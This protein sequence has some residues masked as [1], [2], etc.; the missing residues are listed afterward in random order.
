MKFLSKLSLI[1]FISVSLSACQNTFLSNKQINQGF[2]TELV[3]GGDFLITTAQKITAPSK[4]YVFYI[5]GD[6]M[7]FIGKHR[8]SLNPTPRHQMVL[9]LTAIDQRPNVIY[10]SRPCQYTPMELNPKCSSEYWSTKRMSEETVDSIN[11]V[12]TKINN[13]QKFSLVGFSGGGGI[14]VLIAARNP[15]V[16]DVITIAGNIDHETFTDFHKVTPMT[17]SLNPINY[18][19]KINKL[20]QLHLSGGKDKTVPPIVAE[21]YTKTANSRCVKQRTYPNNEHQKGW[22]KVWPEISAESVNCD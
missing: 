22:E 15:K 4:P 2:K 8:I 21:S 14:A 16:K 18:A 9:D 20:P 13:G 6:G 3:Q 11:Q 7:A 19:L 17:E 1:A 10:I 5:E 12:I